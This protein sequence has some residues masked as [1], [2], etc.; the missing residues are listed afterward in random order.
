M[1]LSKGY[2]NS[3]S[4]R[5]V[6]IL[7]CIVIFSTR[8]PSQDINLVAMNSFQPFVYFD[9]QMEATG[10]AVTVVS[11]LLEEAEIKAKPVAL[12][13]LKRMMLT[14]SERPN[15]LGFALFRTPER[16][17]RYKWIVPVTLPVR[18][19]LIRL[20]S[21]SDIVINTLEDA[22]GYSIGIVDGN[23]LHSFLINSEFEKIDP[24][25]TN[26][27]NYKK[28]FAGRTDLFLAREPSILTELKQL[29][30]SL[31]DIVI[32]FQVTDDGPAWLIANLDTSQDII[33]KLRASYEHIKKE[34]L[35]EKVTKNY[36]PIR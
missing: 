35:I 6:K 36:Y 17:K 14:V 23:N 10:I 24:A 21:R 19:V 4:L 20:R 30:Y 15:T 28:L 34:N 5:Y 1:I 8:T 33:D 12:Y 18:A 7:L 31:E 3:A 13:P 29:G 22:K 2:M 26:A 32:E 11:A 25:P 9:D 16:E 27:Q